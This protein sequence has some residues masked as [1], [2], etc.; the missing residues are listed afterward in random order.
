MECDL[1]DF[2]LRI[3]DRWGEEIYTSSDQYSFW[4]GEFQ[5]IPVADGVYVWVLDYRAISGDGLQ[6]ERSMGHVTLLR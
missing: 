2:N 5:G 6:V 4:D 3:Y 1:I